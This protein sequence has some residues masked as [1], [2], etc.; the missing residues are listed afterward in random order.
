MGVRP[1]FSSVP[2]Y[3]AALEPQQARVL[4]RILATVQKSVPGSRRV[5]SYGIPAFRVDRV[6][7]YCAAFKRHIGIYPPV[8]D[9]ARLRAA[10]KPYANSKGNLAFA[11]D[12]PIPLVLISRVAKALAKQYVQAGASRPARRKA[13]S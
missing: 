2:G 12:E 7:I 11:L 10:L 13:K 9:D 6:F 8:R 3:V 1:T 4:K 5:I